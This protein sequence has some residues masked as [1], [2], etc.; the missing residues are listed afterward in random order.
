MFMC[1]SNYET[2]KVTFTHPIQTIDKMFCDPGANWGIESLKEWIE[3]YES[4]RLTPL[5]DRTVIITS[6]YNM[7]FVKK[8][9]EINVAP[10]RIETL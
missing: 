5:S 7:S 9:L 2:I 3:A 4:T 10:E 8:W 1:N 6:E